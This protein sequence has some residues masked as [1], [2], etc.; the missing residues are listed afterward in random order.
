MTVMERVTGYD[1]WYQTS[2]KDR[3]TGIDTRRENGRFMSA[4]VSG[5]LTDQ[6]D[7]RQYMM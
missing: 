3:R 4:Y 6:I 1:V 5:R 2:R 7:L